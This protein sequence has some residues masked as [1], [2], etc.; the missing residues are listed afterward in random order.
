MRKHG[1]AVALAGAAALMLTTTAPATA[2]LDGTTD[3]EGLFP[4]VGVLQLQFD[5]EWFGFCSG[6]LVTP[7]VV[8]T[9]AHCT[10][11]KSTPSFAIS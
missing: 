9:A 4:N 2:V 6:T 1:T 11:F 5:G 8:L 7:N 3:T 10:D